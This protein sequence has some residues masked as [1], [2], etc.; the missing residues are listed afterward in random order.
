MKI[1]CGG[2]DDINTK[3]LKYLSNHIIEPLTYIINLCMEKCI[4]PDELKKAEIK[5]IHKAN[6]K[7]LPTN[8]RP[9]S[10]ISNIAKIFE[11]V[12]FQRILNFIKKHKILS[13]RQYGFM[14]NFGIKDV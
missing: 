14:Q 2:V 7:Y 12:I 5:P 1:K 3:M 13:A 9:I 4:W 6:S 10:L 8:Y 11:K